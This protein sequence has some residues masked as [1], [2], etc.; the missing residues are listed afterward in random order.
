[1]AEFA[2]NIDRP[3]LRDTSRPIR[4]GF[5]KHMGI[6]TAKAVEL[7][8]NSFTG[9]CFIC[10]TTGCGKSNTVYGI[11]DRML[12]NDIPF[13][14][15]E[16]AK[17]EYKDQYAGVPGIHIFTTNPFIGKILKINPFRFDP[18][19]HVLEH[20]DRLI[21]IFNA[22]W[23]MEAAMPAVL[24]DAMERA[25]VSLGWDLLNREFPDW[26]DNPY[27]KS[28]GGLKNR[29]FSMVYGW[30]IGFLTWFFHVFGKDNI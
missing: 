18:G 24:K 29:Y 1:M 12:Q 15:I 26:H 8:L 25:Y 3:P 23:D 9:H 28:L 5:I 27:L 30:N 4:V 7:D 14:V 10:G 13:L 22:C 17:G 11:M 19:I 16:P 21:E 20:L 2:R 6:V